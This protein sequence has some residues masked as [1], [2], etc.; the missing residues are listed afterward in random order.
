MPRAAADRLEF[1]VTPE[2]KRRLRYAADLSQLQLSDF[3]RTAAEERAEQV[4][5]EHSATVV[6]PD[7]FDSLVSALEEPVV[8]NAALAR[9]ARRADETVVR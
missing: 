9:A 1:R 4:L 7:F 8:P 6:P 5:R 2:V 3:V